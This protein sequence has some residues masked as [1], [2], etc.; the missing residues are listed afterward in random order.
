MEVSATF[1]KSIYDNKTNRNMKFNSFSQ[2]EKLLYKLSEMPRKGKKDAELISPASYV[3][4]TTRANKNVLDW[5]GWTAVDVDDHEFKGNL[6]DELY[7]RFGSLSY[8]CYSTA[9]SS[10]NHPKFRLVFPLSKPVESVKIKH[11]WFALNKELGE[12]GDGQT[13]DL[14]RMYYIP[15]T[16][17]GANNFIF[18]NSGV[19]I[20]PEQLI[21]KHPYTEKRG[22]SFMDRLTPEMQAQVIEHRKNKM[23]NT[24][25]NWSGYRDCPFINKNHIKEWFAISG[26]DNSG[27]Y[28]MIYKIMVS[29]AISA[30]KKEYPI[31]SYEIEQLVRELD[32]ETSR[33]YEKRPLNIEA[34]RAIEYA[35]KNA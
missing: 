27:R 15:A 14:S 20:D 33:R 11:F 1:F 31:S 6:K 3:D 9:S 16:Y 22:S 34:D 2:F 19:Y 17:A 26:I 32:N 28:A 4:D 35:Y 7:N 10:D 21:S 12:I 25:F 5:S 18:S 24:N 23:E 30:I 29:T 8:V 13:K